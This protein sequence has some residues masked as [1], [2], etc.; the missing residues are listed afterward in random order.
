MQ[1]LLV[2]TGPHDLLGQDAAGLDVVPFGHLLDGDL[3]LPLFGLD[4]S[5]LPVDRS[6]LPP[7]ASPPL[8]ELQPVQFATL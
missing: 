5:D 2:L 3:D 1:A 8:F 7:N 6:L 4:A